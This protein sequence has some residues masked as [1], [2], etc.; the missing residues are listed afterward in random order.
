MFTEI[1]KRKYIYVFTSLKI[2]ISKKFKKYI[3]DQSS[4]I[5]YFY[6][7]AIDEIHLIKE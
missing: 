2:A 1:S 3:F 6:L 4:F 5:D 7:L